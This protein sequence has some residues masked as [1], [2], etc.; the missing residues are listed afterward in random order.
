MSFWYNYRSN[1]FVDDDRF[2]EL[3][4]KIGINFYLF[5]LAKFIQAYRFIRC[6]TRI[7]DLNDYFFDVLAEYKLIKNI[8][9]D[10]DDFN[11]INILNL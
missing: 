4:C 2:K 1:S 10:I 5:H 11:N 3:L 9:N 6:N 7:Q 8:D